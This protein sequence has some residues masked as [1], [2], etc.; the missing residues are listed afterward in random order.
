MGWF[1]RRK[2]KP[3][4]EQL[5]HE[6]RFHLEEQIAE[7]VAEGLTPQ[8][9]RRRALVEF[10][11]E[12]QIKEECRDVQRLNP[13]ADLTQDFRYAFRMIRK[14]PGFAALAVI[15]LALGIGANSAVFSVVN[16]LILRP[17]AFPD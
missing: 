10:G 15:T 6:L 17:F 11:G 8:Q 3:F 12:T 5:D 16:A 4:E 14:R 13:A 7:Y 2:K 1:T 9:A